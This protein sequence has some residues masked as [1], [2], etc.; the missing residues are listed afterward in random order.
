MD[1]LTEKFTVCTVANRLEILAFCRSASIPRVSLIV[2]WRDQSLA[3]TESS[4]SC[5]YTEPDSDSISD[6]LEIDAHLS[7]GSSVKPARSPRSSASIV[8][9]SLR[10]CGVDGRTVKTSERVLLPSSPGSEIETSIEKSIDAD[11]NSK[12]CSERRS[13]LIAF[14]STIAPGTRADRERDSEQTMDSTG[15]SSRHHRRN[16]SSDSRAFFHPAFRKYR[17]RPDSKNTHSRSLDCLPRALPP[18]DTNHM[19]ENP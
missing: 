14:A 2:Q 1:V 9:S 6:D 3:E 18:L 15:R 10:L 5:R 8:R 16:H 11:P 13:R 17:S 4:A 7:V 19:S 12:P